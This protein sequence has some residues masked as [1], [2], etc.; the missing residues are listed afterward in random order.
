MPSIIVKPHPSCSYPPASEISKGS[1]SERTTARTDVTL[2]STCVEQ[3][4]AQLFQSQRLATHRCLCRQPE[5]PTPVKK[6]YLRLGAPLDRNIGLGNNARDVDNALT[7]DGRRILDHALADRGVIHKHDG[8]HR[9]QLLAENQEGRLAL[10]AHGVQTST[11]KDL[12]EGCARRDGPRLYQH[13]SS[14]FS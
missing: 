7:G 1:A 11:D 6:T 13:P 9:R 4:A 12:H 2:I 3:E 8:L 5:L 10:A 14:H